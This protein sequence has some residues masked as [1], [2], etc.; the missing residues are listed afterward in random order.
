MQKDR[1]GWTAFMLACNNGQREV[2]E[3]LLDH[4]KRTIDFNAKSD[5][6]WTA[7]MLACRYG[8][9]DVV[10]LL[11]EHSEGNIDF[12]AKCDAGCTAFMYANNQGHKDVVELLLKH[13][14]Q[15]KNIQIPNNMTLLE[16]CLSQISV[17]KPVSFNFSAKLS[18]YDFNFET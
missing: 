8:R 17:E 18:K 14:K 15:G 5:F 4:S 1:S 12:D 10:K 13:A 6:G 7:I 2:V 16:G 9:K 3:L 11:L